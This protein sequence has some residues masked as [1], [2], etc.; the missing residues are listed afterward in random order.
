MSAGQ[1]RK[2]DVLMNKTNAGEGGQKAKAGGIVLL[3]SIIILLLLPGP[4]FGGLCIL[5][6]QDN[7]THH[8][9]VGHKSDPW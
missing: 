2:L 8:Q 1:R 9:L 7:S 3:V 6:S 5:H 4:H